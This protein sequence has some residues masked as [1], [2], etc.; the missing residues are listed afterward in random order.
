[1]LYFVTPT[2]AS[3]SWT[4]ANR[5]WRSQMSKWDLFQVNLGL[6]RYGDGHESRQGQGGVL[7]CCWCLQTIVHNN[8]VRAD[9]RDWAAGIMKSQTLLFDSYWNSQNNVINTGTQLQL[10]DKETIFNW[11]SCLVRFKCPTIPLFTM[12]CLQIEFSVSVLHYPVHELLSL[13][14]PLFP[15][16]EGK[17]TSDYK[18]TDVCKSKPEFFGLFRQFLRA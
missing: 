3:T 14:L 5:S 8:L 13:P 10:A 2:A 7:W 1:M 11:T 17:H 16:N 4:I 6:V 9:N 15:L 18:Q 12:L